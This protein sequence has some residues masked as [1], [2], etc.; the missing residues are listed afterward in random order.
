[1]RTKAIAALM[2]LCLLISLL[3]TIAFAQEPGDT[4]TISTAEDLMTLLS[5]TA[6]DA[7]ATVGVTYMLDADLSI[8][9]SALE[10]SFSASNS[11]R[12]FR[13]VLDGNGHTVT[14]TDSGTAPSQPL[15]DFLQGSYGQY[16]GV[17]N[18]TLVF[19]GDVAGTTV[20]SC[21]TYSNLENLDIRFQKDIVFAPAGEYA[22]AAGVFGFQSSG[23][24]I[25]LRNVSVTATG[26]AP[27]GTIG[28]DSPQNARYVLA[29]GIHTERRTHL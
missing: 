28:S 13:G 19:E 8:D 4:V 22:I 10:T 21:L 20:A 12:T 1:M 16:A 26:E 6:A 18:L 7:G 17:K 5:T 24:P 3:P 9:T 14:V 2:T 11:A 23:S 25:S 29:A 15:F 27:Y